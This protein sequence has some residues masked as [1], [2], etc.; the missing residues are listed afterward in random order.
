MSINLHYLHLHRHTHIQTG[1]RIIYD[2]RFLLQMRNSPLSKSPP[3][4]LATIPDILNENIAGTPPLKTK[5]P[6]PAKPNNHGK[7]MNVSSCVRII[8]I[9]H[10][11]SV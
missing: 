2:R 3:P 6:E 1:T 5:S 11:I 8:V 10:V 7:L 9:L 4:K